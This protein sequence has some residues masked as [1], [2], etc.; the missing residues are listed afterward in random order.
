MISAAE[1][2]SAKPI[3]ERSVREIYNNLPN[4]YLLS[5]C[6][7]KYGTYHVSLGEE[8]EYREL[9]LTNRGWINQDRTHYPQVFRN[10]LGGRVW[11]LNEGDI[12]AMPYDEEE[13]VGFADVYGDYRSG[14]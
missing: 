4:K 7:D 2:Y 1:G 6:F 10:G 11:F 14:W 8:A 12:Y 5:A 9:I 3:S 13:F